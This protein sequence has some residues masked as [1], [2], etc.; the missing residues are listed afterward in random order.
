MWRNYLKK[1]TKKIRKRGFK[2][3][4]G[5]IFE[6]KKSKFQPRVSILLIFKKKKRRGMVFMKSRISIAIKK[7]IL[8][9]TIFNQKT[10]IDLGN[11]CAGD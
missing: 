5:N 2:V 8:L 1:K 11:L 6:S 10:S 9:A 4:K 3:K 7:P